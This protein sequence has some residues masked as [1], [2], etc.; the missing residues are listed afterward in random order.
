M[1]RLEVQDPGRDSTVAP[2]QGDER[3][4]GFG[5]NIVQTL[6]ERWGFERVATGGTRLWARL[7]LEP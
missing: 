6:S 1:I 3:D 5:L 4:G 2:R 7:A